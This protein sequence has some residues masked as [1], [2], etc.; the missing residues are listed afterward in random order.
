MIP[1]LW[2]WS[3]GVED[4]DYDKSLFMI[5]LW[6]QFCVAYVADPDDDQSLLIF[7][8]DSR[9]MTFVWRMCRSGSRP[10]IIYDLL[11]CQI[12][13]FGLAL[14]AA[15]PNNGCFFYDPWCPDLWLCSGVRGRSGS[16]PVII[17]D[18]SL[19]PNLWLWS[20]ARGWCGSRPLIKDLLWFQICDF[21]LAQLAD[22]VHDQ[23]LF[24]IFCD[25]RFVTLV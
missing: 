2:L 22:P 12:C 9:F 23:S 15:D 17:Y 14:L 6:F 19:I 8:R 20:G 13:D 21:V 11:W 4:P 5:V 3:G 7:F 1:D 25:F 10:V 18:H 16:Q 24:M